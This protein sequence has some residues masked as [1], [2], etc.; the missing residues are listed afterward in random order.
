MQNDY[1]VE[2]NLQN[3]SCQLSRMRAV[4]YIIEK[5]LK[6]VIAQGQVNLSVVCLTG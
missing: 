6:T 1:S 2:N 4:K 5:M 3:G